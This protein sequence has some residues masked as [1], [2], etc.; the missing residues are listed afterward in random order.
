MIW[1][2]V[3]SSH[4]RRKHV[5]CGDPDWIQV[6]HVVKLAIG[7]IITKNREQGR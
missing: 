4:V 1:K 3:N 2:R 6:N 7:C 5:A